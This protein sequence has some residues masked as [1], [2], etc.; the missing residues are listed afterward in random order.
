LTF[1]PCVLVAGSTHRI[2]YGAI[3]E[4]PGGS[5]RPAT[6]DYAQSFDGI[7]WTLHRTVLAPGAPGSWDDGA[8]GVARVLD[9]GRALRMWFDGRSVR[10]PGDATSGSSA[11]GLATLE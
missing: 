7:D 5:A 1:G 9:S 6:I 11:I 8:L 4:G 10:V 3:H 2:W